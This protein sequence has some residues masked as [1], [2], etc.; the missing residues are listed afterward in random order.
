MAI[1]SKHTPK[2]TVIVPIYN[3]E[4]YLYDALE[5]IRQQ[6]FSDFECICVNDG[7]TDK[8]EDIINYF[9]KDD[10]RFFLI[11]KKNGGVSSARN[12]GMDV[13]RG[14][15]IYFMDHDDVIPAY[16]LKKLLTAIENFNADM[17]RGR[18]KMIAENFTLEE[19]P[20][21]SMREKQWFFDNPVV[22]LRWR[23]LTKYK[24][25]CWIWLCLF[26]KKTIE[27]IRFVEEL[28]AGGEDNLFMFD[29]LRVIKN[30]VQIEDVTA[31]HR[32]SKTSVTLGGRLH[33]ALVTMPGTIIPYVYANYT[34]AN[35]IDKRLL[36]WI[37]NWE[38]R[39]AYRFLI[40]KPIHKKG[41]EQILE[42]VREILVKLSNTPE[43]YEVHRRWSFRQKIFSQLL[44]ER[45]YKV[46]QKLW[47][48]V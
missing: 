17:A 36:Q 19:M 10:D 34:L 25:W 12:A 11:N 22:D 41:S 30:Y 16:T 14:E 42:A 3:D 28:R 37:Y 21:D 6:T 40:R 26:R 32:Y 47:L 45:K 13:A 29:V 15:Y 48:L 9:V 31:C 46:L 44:I 4:L 7:S 33:P 24:R 18:V 35:D 23:T 43:F 20:K 1:D 8:S 2:I 27:N 5:S 38:A 39:N